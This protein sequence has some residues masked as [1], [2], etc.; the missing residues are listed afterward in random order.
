VA[1]SPT[2]AI[3]PE[4]GI[5][6]LIRSLTSDSKRLASDEVRLAKLEL[7]ESARTGVRGGLWMA[8]AL[9][10]GIV[11]LVAL[12]VLLIAAS[13]VFGGANYWA[14][15]L[16]VGGLELVVGWVLLRR[17]LEAVKTPQLTLPESRASLQDTATWVRHPAR[18]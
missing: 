11:A 7:H 3:D 18:H 10:I 16:I 2:S 15:A 4:T 5:P 9:G 14:G 17:G 12:T 8:L 6:D 1:V 13:G